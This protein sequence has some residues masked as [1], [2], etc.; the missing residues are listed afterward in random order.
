MISWLILDVSL[1]QQKKEAQANDLLINSGS[2]LTSHLEA[3]QM[4]KAMGFT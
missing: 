3:P 4:S 2:L 1:E